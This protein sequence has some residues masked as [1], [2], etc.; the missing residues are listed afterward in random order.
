MR[1]L[2][3]LGYISEPHAAIA[4]RE[5]RD[6]PQEGEFGLFLGTAHPAKFKESVEAILGRT[7]VAESAGAAGRSAAAVAHAAGRLCR[8]AQIPDGAAGLKF[9]RLECEKPSCDGF[10]RFIAL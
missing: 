5:L 7:V 9:G 1:E 8:A 6:Q 3:E 4:Y 2:A 10:F